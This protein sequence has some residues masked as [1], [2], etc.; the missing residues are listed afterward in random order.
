MFSL[1]KTRTPE[2]LIKFY[3]PNINK[4]LL[5]K[6][7]LKYCTIKYFLKNLYN[8]YIYITIKYKKTTNI[9]VGFLQK[10]AYH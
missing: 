5:K 4:I 8:T 3:K 2:I 7:L 6:I 10:N 9:T 1:F